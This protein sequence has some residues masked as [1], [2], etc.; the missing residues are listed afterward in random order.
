MEIIDQREN[1]Q[2]VVVRNSSLTGAEF[3]NCRAEEVSFRNV[4]LP[5]FRVAC[6]DLSGAHFKDVNMSR[7]FITDANLSDL[8]IDG[9]QL[10]GAYI[11]NIGLPPK[12]HPAYRE[13]QGRQ[14]PL[15]FEMCELTGSTISLS[16][17][18]GV[19]IEGCNIEGLTIDG[20]D[21]SALLKRYRTEGQPE[22]KANREEQPRRTPLLKRTGAA[23]VPVSD[24]EKA[25]DWYCRILGIPVESVRITNGHL[26]SI[27]VEGSGL[28][29]DT[30]PMWGGKEPGGPPTFQT[31]GF[32]LLTDDLAASYKY[33]KEQGAELVTEIEYDHWF[34]FRDPDGNLLMVCKA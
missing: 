29:L 20:I 16:D 31:P 1:K 8:E 6:A 12:G 7:T 30:M 10:G 22:A 26:C 28:I 14:R 11:H 32:M 25:R 17:L 5:N 2:K 34:A 24:I 19:R 4:S 18:S 15:R 23:F 9:A 13:D 3:E 27:P 21:V 33:M